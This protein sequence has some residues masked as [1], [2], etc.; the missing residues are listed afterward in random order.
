MDAI[1]RDRLSL[2]AALGAGVVV[3]ISG[4]YLYYKVNKCV[5]RELNHLSGTI[6]SLRREIEELKSTATF[7]REKAINSSVQKGNVSSSAPGTKFYSYTSSLEDA[8]EEYFDF[9]D[10]EE[11]IGA[12]SNVNGTETDITKITK[13]DV[14]LEQL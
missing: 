10:T 12:W 4:I 6:D 8:D 13:L 5:T 11:I 1:L 2:I 3:G 14:L 7:N 9:T